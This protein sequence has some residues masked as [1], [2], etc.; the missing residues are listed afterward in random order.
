M[1]VNRSRVWVL[2]GILGFLA[3]G[4][5]L[6]LFAVQVLEHRRFLAEAEKQ[7]E[8]LVPLE[9]PRGTILTRDGLLLAG[10]VEKVAVYANPKRIPRERWSWVAERLAPIV[11]R[12]A[13][14]ILQE[15]QSRDGFFY[16]AKNLDPAVATPVA[17]LGLKGVGT[18]PS[19]QRIYPQ[20]PF[21]AAVVGFVNR[22]G[23]G[24]AGVEAAC[25]QLLAGEEGL[26]R[27]VR[28]GKRVPTRLAY[29][30]EKPGR[31]GF[32]LVLTLDARVQWVLEEE[33]ARTLEEVGGRGA[34]AVALDPLTGEVR[35]MASLPSYDPQDLGRFPK[36]HWHNRAVETVLEPGSTFKPFVV[37]AALTAGVVGSESLV[38]CSGGG[39]EV[40]GFFIR[41]HARYGVLPLRQ[42]LA[43]SSNAGTIRLALRTPEEQLD[44]TI[45]ALGF[46]QPTRV[47]LPAES[48]GLYRRWGKGSWSALT[49]AGLAIGQEISVT[50]LQLARAYAALANGGL[51][52]QPTLL[53]EVRDRDGNP[54]A[55][56]RSAST[57]RV[58]PE[59]VARAVAGMLEAVVEEGTGKA[60][61]V[62]GFRVAGKTGT[63]QKAVGGSYKAGRHAAW[64]AGFFPMPDPKLVLVVCVD[65]PQASYWAA[66]VAAPT[67]G[68]IAARLLPLLGVLPQERSAA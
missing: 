55:V 42:V 59:P 49:P 51:L 33:L 27:L 36:E 43:F 13:Q 1:T 6:R 37:A 20:G 48:P 26:A 62:A 19:Q 25:Q 28:D 44:Q 38:D 45:W 40:A 47:E 68:R 23:Q 67:F 12:S 35:G 66:E 16:L 63:A 41:D 11:G 18:L 15:L 57:K 46:G 52:V 29:K 54:V 65:E 61:A 53:A 50:A 10:S 2:A 8:A 56:R 31:P 58:L 64:F 34:A 21:A 17:Q 22:E 9:P 14:E 7:Q 39:V 60:A 5:V 32:Q 24:Q 3:L 4:V 30:L